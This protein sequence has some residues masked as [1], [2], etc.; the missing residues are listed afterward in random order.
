V[1]A[2]KITSSNNK[3]LNLAI[4]GF[5]AIGIHLNG[6]KAQYNVIAGCHIGNDAD[7][8]Q[9]LKNDGSGLACTNGAHHNTF[10]G[11]NSTDRNVISGNINY[12]INFEQSNNNTILNNYIGVDATGS[13]AL[14]NGVLKGKYSGI[15]I[16][17]SGHNIIGTGTPAGRNVISGN[18]NAGVLIENSG[19]DSNIVQGN[20]I[21]VG[22]DGKTAIPNDQNGLRIKKGAHFNLIGGDEPGQ[23]NV[24]SGN[25][26]SAVQLWG[27][28]HHNILRFNIIGMNATGIIVVPNMHNGI[29]CFG[30]KDEGFPTYN[31]IGPKNI[32]CGNGVED[33]SESWAGISLD[34]SGTAYN[35]CFGN[36][37]GTNPYTNIKSGQPTGILIQRGAHHNIIGSDNII[38]N[39]Y[40]NGVLVKDDTTIC[41]KI[42]RNLIYNNKKAIENINGGNRDLKPPAILFASSSE[43]SG[44]APNFCTIEFYSSTNGQADA[45]LGTTQ[46]NN[47]GY[48]Q[49]KG[50]FSRTLVVSLAIDRDDNTSELSSSSSV[51][52]DLLS[53]DVKHVAFHKVVLIWSTASERNNIGFT[54]EK[55]LLSGRFESIAFVNGQGT[56]NKTHQYQFVDSIEKPGMYIYRLK[57]ID[58]EGMCSFSPEASIEMMDEIQPLKIFP[59]PFNQNTKIIFQKPSDKQCSVLIYDILGQLIYEF[60]FAP[61][62]ELW[63]E[64]IWNGC[65]IQGRLAPSGEYLIAVVTREHTMVQKCLLLR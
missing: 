64:I 34:N 12:G 1:P 52:V 45:Y 30:S 56:T 23:A 43:V 2:F 61:S 4:G 37:I 26:S 44:N 15:H 14:P 24:I 31:I 38:T 60:E 13:M 28:C 19:A 55:K 51:P 47:K 54:V 7:G 10:G 62:E 58:S 57:Q 27:D 59:N 53:F 8:I 65:D 40:Y 35:S 49:W 39:S 11:N 6:T 63:Q 29:Y 50:N 16:S 5:P 25:K 21:G 46:S 48:F 9:Q 18:L 17:Y 20:Y 32:I 41:N 36:Y 3:I 22:A 33:Y 42:T